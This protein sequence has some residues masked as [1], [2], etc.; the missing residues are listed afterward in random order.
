MQEHVLGATDLG[1]IAHS[2]RSSR[3]GAVVVKDDIV[4]ARFV[5][6]N[7]AISSGGHLDQRR[8]IGILS[9]QVLSRDIVRGLSSISA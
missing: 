3:V 7:T 6:S 5:Q 1:K 9:E 2:P 8:G 4:L